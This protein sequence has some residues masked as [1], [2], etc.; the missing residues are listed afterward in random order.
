MQL[1]FFFEEHL[2]DSGEFFLSEESSRHIVQ[3]LRMGEKAPVL[4]T[5]GKGTKL[6][7]TIVQADRKKTRIR[8]TQRSFLAKAA[9][10]IA[11]AMPLLKN[12]SRFEWFLEKAAE[13]GVSQIVP[14][15]SERTEKQHF[16]MD[17]AIHILI[18]AMLQ[19]EQAWLPEIREPVSFEQIV[20]SQ[21]SANK[22]IAHCLPGSRKQSLVEVP[23]LPGNHLILIGP[24]G[25][26]TQKEID[27]ALG[28]HFIAVTLGDNRLRT[29]TAAM[30]A[31]VLI[32][33]RVGRL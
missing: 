31:A 26:F 28:N 16:R 18:S 30:V 24:E 15:V 23:L 13:I 9:P 27:W 17:R 21:G 33:N 5:D 2:P 7:V 8:T 32:L 22:F 1:P 3:V 25:D 14:M 11:I 20:S 10:E 12:K 19:S 6:T 29:E 4:I